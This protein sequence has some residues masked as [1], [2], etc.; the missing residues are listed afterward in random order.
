LKRLLLAGAALTLAACSPDMTAPSKSLVLNAPLMGVGGT[1]TLADGSEVS[2]GFD[3]NGYNDC[4]GIF[5]GTGSSWCVAGGQ[6]PDCMAPFSNDKVIMKWNKA[7]TACN[8]SA[9]DPL[10][11]AGAWTDNEWNGNVAGGSGTVWHYKIKWVGLPC[12]ETNLNWSAGGYCI[13]GGYEVL[14]DQGH[15]PSQG[16]GH[17]WFA[18]AKPNGY[19][20]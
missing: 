15:D 2:T 1:C 16:P 18:H 12:D 13:W 9:G 4:A 5:N 19:G 8:D 6:S 11:C 20:T 17:I 14:M 10:A 7:W 3:Q